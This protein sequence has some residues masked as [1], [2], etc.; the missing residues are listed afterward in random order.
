[1]PRFKQ[2][3]TAGQMGLAG[4]LALVAIACKGGEATDEDTHETPKVTATD[5]AMTAAA[6]ANAFGL[7]LFRQLVNAQPTDNLAMSG[8]SAA[9]ALALFKEACE[10]DSRRV[11]TDV[12]GYSGESEGKSATDYGDLIRVLNDSGDA[13]VLM[14]NALFAR[15]GVTFEKA[16]MGTATGPFGAEVRSRDFLDP[17]TVRELNDWCSKKTQRMI[18]RMLDELDPNDFAVI[19]NALYFKGAWQTEF[20]ASKTAL[21]DFHPENGEPFKVS[22]MTGEVK[23]RMWHDKSAGVVRLPYRGGRFSMVLAMPAAPDGK[24]ADLV[25]KLTPDTWNAW[26]RRV[27]GGTNDL[28]VWLPKFKLTDFHDLN[29]PLIALGLNDALTAG[30]AD[31][32]R[33]VAGMNREAKVEAEVKQRVVV[34]VDEK[35]TK[36]AAVTT[37][38]MGVASAPMEKFVPMFNRPFLFAIVDHRTGAILFLGQVMDPRKE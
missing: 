1:M 33:M 14:A 28:D 7:K 19:L 25:G 21:R 31:Y 22:M 29:Q 26:W 30:R 15:Q 35:G 10:G 6:G 9:M 27:E 12:L 18:P 38:E 8:A 20:E 5:G 16:F 3:V 34:E 17:A 13:S 11:V 32:S 2:F 4:T 36:A 23:G 37:V 24:L